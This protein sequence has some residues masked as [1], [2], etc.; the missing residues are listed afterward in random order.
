MR[1]EKWGEALAIRI[2]DDVARRL[3]VAEGD[4]VGLHV[5][6]VGLKIARR[7]QPQEILS[8]LE[9]FRGRLMARRQIPRGNARAG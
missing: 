2:P 8:G 3:G 5:D 4:C 9:K 1:V 7:P 6:G